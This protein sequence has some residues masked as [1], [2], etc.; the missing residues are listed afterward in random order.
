[1]A[2]YRWIPE[3]NVTIRAPHGGGVAAG[4]FH[5]QCPESWFMKFPGLRIL[6]PSTVEDAQN[7]LYTAFFD[8]NPVLFFEHK[9]L[10]RSIRADVE[11]HCKIIDIESA[12]IVKHGED[13]TIITYGMGVYWAL[14]AA[15]IFTRQ[16][17]NIEIVDLRSLAPLDWDAITTSVKKTGRVLLLEEPSEVLGPMSEISAGISERAFNYLD[18]PIIRCSSLHTPVPFNKNL[19]EGYLAS[20][21]LKDKLDQL[22]TY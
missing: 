18:A 22:L 19:E 6:V 12:R 17:I 1:M 10:Y 7:M 15:E 21:R 9:K 13:L 20:Y 3:M 4:P 8:P 5:S 2:C 11:E 16:N 14:E